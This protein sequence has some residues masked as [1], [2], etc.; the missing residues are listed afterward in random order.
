LY[1][2]LGTQ[3]SNKIQMGETGSNVMYSPVIAKHE[4]INQSQ[5][6]PLSDTENESVRPVE[7]EKKQEATKKCVPDYSESAISFCDNSYA[8]N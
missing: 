7:E 1:L 6:I 3:E 2:S 5:S 4:E 8:D